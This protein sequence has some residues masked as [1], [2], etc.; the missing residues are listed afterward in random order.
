MTQDVFGSSVGVG[1]RCHLSCQIGRNKT[2]AKSCPI[3]TTD[4]LN[5]IPFKG[6]DET[7]EFVLSGLYLKYL[8]SLHLLIVA[9]CFHHVKGIDNLCHH[10]HRGKWF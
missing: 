4:T 10:I 2:I 5:I 1:F 9:V 6:A 3:D 8:P 7:E